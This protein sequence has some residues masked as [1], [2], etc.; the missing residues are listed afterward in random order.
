V[1]KAKPPIK[2]SNPPKVATF[3]GKGQASILPCSPSPPNPLISPTLSLPL[4]FPP[5]RIGVCVGAGKPRYDG[6]NSEGNRFISNDELV[7]P[8]S[9]SCGLLWAPHISLR[10]VVAVTCWHQFGLCF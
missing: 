1:Q 2:P 7:L 10:F 6:S 4:P 8:P 9:L 5:N 3:L